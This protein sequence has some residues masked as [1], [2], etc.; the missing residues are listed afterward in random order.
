MSQMM[1]E[2]RV[3]EKKTLL[4]F[5]KG[6]I[7]KKI[8]TGI[9]EEVLKTESNDNEMENL[10]YDGLENLAGYICHKLKNE[11]PN[12]VVNPQTDSNFTWVNQLSEANRNTGCVTS[13]IQHAQKVLNEFA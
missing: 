2:I 10:Q 1:S 6:S 3:V 9:Q 12:L 4:P 5:Q 8:N 13:Q 7:F 11:N